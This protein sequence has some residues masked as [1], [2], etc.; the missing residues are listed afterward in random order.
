MKYAGVL[1]NSTVP[2]AAQLWFLWVIRLETR[3]VSLHNQRSFNNQ[4]SYAKILARWRFRSP[5][6]L[7]RH[8]SNRSRPAVWS[9]V[10][11]SRV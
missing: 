3:R 11:A 6:A 9:F 2:A 10:N 1:K 4:L 7:A 8:I 5:F